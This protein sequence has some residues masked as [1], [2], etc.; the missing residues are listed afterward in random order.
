MSEL[1]ARSPADFENDVEAIFAKRM[2][3]MNSCIGSRFKAKAERWS[4]N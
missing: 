2:P 1:D 4:K 3:M